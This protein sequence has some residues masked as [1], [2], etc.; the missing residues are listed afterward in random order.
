MDRRTLLKAL[1]ASLLGLSVAAASAQADDRY[2]IVQSTTSTQNSG[3]FDYM[4]PR[5]TEEN[6]IE[7]RVVAV[8][9]GQAL[10]NARNC[11]GDVLMVHAKPA[12]ETFVEEG[13]G[14]KRHDVMYND[15][16]IVGP[17]ADPAGVGGME[18]APAALEKIAGAQAPFASRGDDSG[19]HKKEM[20]LWKET[21]V[22]PTAASGTWYRETGSGMGATL[23]VAVGMDAYAMTDRATWISFANKG[24]FEI[25][26]EG[27]PQLFNQYGVILVSPEKCP[28][29][30][31]ELGQKFVDWVISDEGQ[32]VIAS[33]E[34][35]GQQLFYPNAR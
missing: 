3:L 20:R 15:F 6:G 27:D 23:N 7:V 10:K 26:V 14:V 19:T 32:A 21:G 34:V 11:D 16:V 31:A 17:A 28:G 29:V 8:G 12:E 5:F 13:Y 35:D 2:I 24:D 18:D 9:T 4:L 30:K 1:S 33:Y 22:D 25:L